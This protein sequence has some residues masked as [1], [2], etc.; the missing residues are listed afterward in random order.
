[1]R[2]TRYRVPYNGLTIEID[3]FHGVAAGVI[4][5]EVE[6]PNVTARDAFQKPDWMG[7]EV[8]GAKQYCNHFLAAE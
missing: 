8:T 1:M 3:V 5:A 4:V 6:F 7:D 2:K